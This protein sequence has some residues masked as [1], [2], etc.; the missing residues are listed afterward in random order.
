MTN[1]PAFNNAISWAVENGIT[2]G[3]GGNKFSPN[4]ACTR[5]QIVTFLYKA[6]N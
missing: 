2:S 1:N 4:K 3:T 5:E 6:Y